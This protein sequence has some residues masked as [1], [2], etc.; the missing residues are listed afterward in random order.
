MVVYLI[1]CKK[2][3]KQYVGVVLRGFAHV[4]IIT[5]VITGSFVGAIQVSFH[6]QFMLDGHCGIND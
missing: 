6:A 3:K 1:T 2:C 5:A 4:S